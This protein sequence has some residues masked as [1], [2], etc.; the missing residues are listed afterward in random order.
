M[1]NPIAYIGDMKS[2]LIQPEELNPYALQAFKSVKSRLD[3]AISSRLKSSRA[4]R[5][6]GNKRSDLPQGRGSHIDHITP[7]SKGGS[8]TL[9]N[10]QVLCAPCNL[11]KGNRQ[12]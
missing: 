11:T 12:D 6:H 2:E 4:V 3:P 8:T 10:L 7:F 9:E 1:S 5:R